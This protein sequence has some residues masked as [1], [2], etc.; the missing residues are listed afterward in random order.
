MIRYEPDEPC[1]PM[2]VLLA[3]FQGFMSTLAPIVLVVA[4]TVLGG[5]QGE[6]YLSWAVSVSLLIAGALTALQSSRIGRFG[7]G[8][9][10]IMGPTPNFVAVSALALAHG[11]PPLLASLTVVASLFYLA[12]ALWLPLLRRVITPVVSGTVL[13]LIGATVLPISIDRIQE[14]PES[15]PQAAGPVIALA[16]LVALVGLSLRVTKAWRLWSP[17][18]AIACGCAVAAAF[19]VYELQPVIDAAWVGLPEGGLPG[20]DLTPGADFWA[21]LP[22]F[23]VV[24]LVGGVKNIS[25]CIAI[26]QASWR[27]QRVTDFR[28]VQGSLNTN[29]LGILI[30][31]LAGA[32]PTTVY[33][34]SSVLLVQLTGVATRR[35]GF[36]VG[37]LLAV[38][39]LLPK[40]AAVLLAIPR[41]VMG[42]YLLMAVGLL[43]VAGVATVSRDGLD[44]RKSIV[45]GVSFTLGLG[46]DTQTVFADLLGDTWGPLLDNGMLIGALAAVAMTLFLD[47]TNPERPAKLDLKLD[48]PP[49]R[50]VDD[51]LSEFAARAGWSSSSAQRLR[52]AGEETLLS[53]IKHDKHD[54]SSDDDPARLTLIARPSGKAVELEFMAVFDEENIEDRLAY[55]SEEIE[56]A[57]G[58]AEGEIPSLLLRHY[59]SSVHHQKFHGLDVVTV[60]VQRSS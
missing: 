24:T 6:G 36:V 18:I 56:G 17:L 54:E 39:A 8:H 52:A 51:F 3:G 5:G 25:D 29:G 50:A 16:T 12:L 59:A 37:A 7:A 11:G 34:S 31:G 49:L 48:T 57:G 44:A 4:V 13:M 19:G 10:L 2:T 22:A 14:V 1:P 47:A 38:M 27:R 41:P 58:L 32:P 40:L 55:L 26:Q 43:F 30:S 9:L 42:A 60:Q 35:V 45:V 21:L 23:A 15:S 20:F 33:S 28:Q 46:L 53:L